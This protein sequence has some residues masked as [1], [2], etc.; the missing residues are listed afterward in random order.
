MNANNDITVS[1]AEFYVNMMEAKWGYGSFERGPG[2]TI[3]ETETRLE[4]GMTMI[5]VYT[6]ENTWAVWAVYD[7]N[8]NKIDVYGEC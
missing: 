5:Y 7:D 2:A 6:N 4:D 1:E 3:V 8:G